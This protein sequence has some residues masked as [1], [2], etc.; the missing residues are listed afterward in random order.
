MK[1]DS[2]A[3]EVA[4]YVDALRRMRE[5][6]APS[7]EDDAEVVCQLIEARAALKAAAAEVVDAADAEL[8]KSLAFFSDGVSI[9]TKRYYVGYD[10]KYTRTATHQQVVDAVALATTMKAQDSEVTLEPEDLMAS[11]AW[12]PAALRDYVGTKAFD[13]L[14][15]SER[16]LDEKAGKPRKSVKT[17]D[18]R[19]GGPRA[20]IP[21][22]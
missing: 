16:L 12:Q 15:S 13:A 18:S 10:W 20:K 14:F 7:E 9:G 5:G 1:L 19:F 4:E 3:T 2:L 11:Q 22:K 21:E 6:G 8:R 17:A